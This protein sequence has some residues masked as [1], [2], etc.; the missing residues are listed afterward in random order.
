[1]REK[2]TVSVVVALNSTVPA[3]LDL[4]TLFVRMSE[5]VASDLD[6]VWESETVPVDV[7]LSS[8][9]NVLVTCSDA[10]I[11]VKVLLAV[12]E[13]YSDI[14]SVLLTAVEGDTVRL[15]KY[16]KVTE[17]VE[18]RVSARCTWRRSTVYVWLILTD[19]ADW[20]ISS[21]R[22]YMVR[23][24]DKDTNVRVSTSVVL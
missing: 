1:L 15:S 11:P 5:S 23:E 6:V 9:V 21:V 7:M 24:P 22:V 12:G 18:V 16:D 4:V 20:L 14:V 2:V 3:V 13:R 17:R 10:D 19:A 8:S